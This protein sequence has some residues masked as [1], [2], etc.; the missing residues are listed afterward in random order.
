MRKAPLLSL[1]CPPCCAFG[2]RLGRATNQLFGGSHQAYGTLQNSLAATPGIENT[3]LGGLLISDLLEAGVKWKGGQQEFK[4]DFLSRT[5]GARDLTG[6]DNQYL[7]QHPPVAEVQ[8]VLSKYGLGEN[9]FEHKSDVVK[10][11]QAGLIN[12]KI[13]YDEMHKKGW[14]SQKVYD[15]AKAAGFPSMYGE[16]K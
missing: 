12:G 2:G 4:Q 13:A 9:G 3:P 10:Q 7:K 8:K 14:I 16:E 11:Y 15:K 1:T 6:A 5:G